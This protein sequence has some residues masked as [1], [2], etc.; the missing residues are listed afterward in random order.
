V[1]SPTFTVEGA[2]VLRR[3]SG[4]VAAADA[5]LPLPRRAVI[6]GARDVG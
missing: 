4:A 2:L 5:L 1:G 6:T 3:A